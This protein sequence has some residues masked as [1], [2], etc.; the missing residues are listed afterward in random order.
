MSCMAGPSP[1]LR[2]SSQRAGAAGAG[3]AV[4]GAAA[5]GRE[6]AGALPPVLPSGAELVVLLRDA[7]LGLRDKNGTALPER[8]VL[9]RWFDAADAP[10]SHVLRAAFPSSSLMRLEAPS[11][12]EL[13]LLDDSSAPLASSPF[14]A[15]LEQVAA[16]LSAGLRPARLAGRSVAEGLELLVRWLNAQPDEVLAGW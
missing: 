3:A 9:D 4:D 14:G 11:D 1:C 16:N 7:S 10:V 5:M 15:A 12:L 2:G 6:V 13:E 8:A